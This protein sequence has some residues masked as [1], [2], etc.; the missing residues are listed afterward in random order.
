MDLSKPVLVTGATGYVAGVLI[1][2]LLDAGLTV[3]CTVRN[4]EKKG[5][6]GHVP[7]KRL[8]FFQADL[9]KERSFDSAM[10]NC[11]V[12]FHTASPVNLD[13]YPQNPWEET[14]QP[15]VFGTRNVLKT[16]SRTPSVHTVVLTSSIGAIYSDNWDTHVLQP[17]S[18]NVFNQTASLNYHAYFYSKTQAE[19]TAWVIAG[20]QTQWRLK[21][22][23]PGMVLGPGVVWP[24]N[25]ETCDM[26]RQVADGRMALGAPSLHLPL[27]DVRDVA[28]A[29]L[30]IAFS[31]DSPPRWLLVNQVV[32]IMELGK[33]VGKNFPWIWVPRW[34]VPMWVVWLLAPFL[35]V[36]LRRRT[37]YRNFGVVPKIDCDYKGKY[38]YEESMVAMVEQMIEAGVVSD[39]ENPKR[40][41]TK[42]D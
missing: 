18:N 42:L 22:V 1:E 23:N 10:D 7:H 27:V 35:P 37:V 34:T 31:A 26:F 9:L 36:P 2:K 3:H 16:A 20:S 17:A 11:A 6:L 25:S 28:D 13:A 40:K 33:V 21:V 38:S 41:Q 29:H 24:A 5:P 15:A 4:L 8:R 39:N 14:V 30:E 12:V 19:L 32:S